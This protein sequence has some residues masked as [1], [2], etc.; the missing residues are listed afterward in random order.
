MGAA[1]RSRSALHG[2]RWGAALALVACLAPLGWVWLL[3]AGTR[4][5]SVGWLLGLGD[6]HGY[7]R[8]HGPATVL[9]MVPELLLLAVVGYGLVAAGSALALRVLRGAA[10]RRLAG[11][12]RV[13]LIAAL[14]VTV[15]GQV[16]T[17]DRLVS[18]WAQ[19]PLDI[20]SWCVCAWFAWVCWDL[21]R[22]ARA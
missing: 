17:A 2:T 9:G 5:A 1:D 12:Q 6:D 19:R 13:G 4:V 15:P 21:L 3:G 22:E 16:W 7:D 20:V 8:S 10:S 11:W 14:V 18:A